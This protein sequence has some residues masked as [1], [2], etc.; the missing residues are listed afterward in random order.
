MIRHATAQDRE[1]LLRLINEA[2]LVERFFVDGDRIAPDVLTRLMGKGTFLIGEDDTRVRAC[3]YVEVRGE[4]GYFG[5]LSV[6]PQSQR[7]GWGRRMIAAAEAHCR[8]A[9]CT[10]LDINVVNLRTELPPFYRKLGYVE[11]GTAEFT[12]PRATKPCH[13]IVMTKN[14]GVPGG[15]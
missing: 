1:T 6:D 2:Y 11:T 5:L 13:M 8:E 15:S 12:D 7:G 10:V 9:G 3:V 4:R 14:L